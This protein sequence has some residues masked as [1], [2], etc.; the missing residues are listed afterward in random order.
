MWT[1]VEAV[2]RLH[3]AER[4][5]RHRSA[6]GCRAAARA[7]MRRVRAGLHP[8]LPQHAAAGAAL[9]LLLRASGR[10]CR[11][12][13]RPAARGRCSATSR[14]AII[15]LSL[16][17]GA[18]NVEIFRSGIEAVP[19]ADGRGGRVARLLAG[20]RPTA[21]S[22]CRSP[23]RI[24][25]PA[26]NN[27]LVNLVKTTTHR[28]RDRGAGD[29]S[30]SP[31]QIWSDVGQRP[32][33]DERAARLLRRARRRARVGDAPLGAGAA[34]AGVRRDERRARRHFPSLRAGIRACRRPTP[35]RSARLAGLARAA[36]RPRSRAGACA[37]AARRGPAPR[38]RAGG[39]RRP[40]PVIAGARSCKWSPLLAQA[41][42][43]FNIAVSVLAMAI[44]TVAGLALGLAQLSLLRAGAQGRRGSSRS[45]SA[46]RR[47]WCCCSIVMLL[48]PFEVTA[49]RRHRSRCRPGSRRRSACRC[50]SWR[51]SSEIVRGAVQLD[52][53]QPVGIGRERSPSRAARR[54]G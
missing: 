47:G 33:D 25:L 22:C 18:F 32:R 39:S 13:T 24:C 41:A 3:R 40:A 12:V 53:D 45:S 1:T 37:A 6:R 28:L 27:N 44:G 21:T 42:S 4:R 9:L 15:S 29:C 7:L 17:A 50:R 34:R 26:L 16:F 48:L 46:T 49:A 11:M 36:V 52:P 30:T 51:T 8:V 14:W 19:K 20:C 10:C 5:D 54:C 38:R 35:V 43:L 2:G 23:F 31:A